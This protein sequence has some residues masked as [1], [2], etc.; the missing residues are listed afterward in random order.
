MCVC[1]GPCVQSKYMQMPSKSRGVGTLEAGVMSS[2][3]QP[4]KVLG[5]NLGSLGEQQALLTTEPSLQAILF[6][7]VKC[8]CVCMCICVHWGWSSLHTCVQVPVGS[9]EGI[10]LPELELQSV[11]SCLVWCW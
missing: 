5:T 6:Y 10:N 9:G 11:T 7:G 3:E 1:V 8:V 4:T 2:C